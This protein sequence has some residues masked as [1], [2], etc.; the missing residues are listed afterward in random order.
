MTTA[1]AL[2]PG[3]YARD[4][5]GRKLRYLAD[6]MR[7][8]EAYELADRIKDMIAQGRLVYDKERGCRRG[9]AFRDIVILFQAMSKVTLYEEVFK[10]REIPYLT[11]AGRG[12]FDRQEVWD[13]LDLLQF[14]HNPADDLSLASALRSPLFA[15]SDDTLFALRCCAR[16]TVNFC[17]CGGRCMSPRR[18]PRRSSPSLMALRCALRWMC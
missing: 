6:D 11:V 12:Y 5:R 14:L 2:E 8:W 16:K 13:M 10:S 9:I 17:R 15:F 3:E 7:R 4:K 18:A 1:S